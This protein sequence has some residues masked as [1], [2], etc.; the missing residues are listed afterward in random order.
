MIGGLTAVVLLVR[1]EGKKINAGFAKRRYSSRAG[2]R[3]S[4]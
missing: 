1:L 4:L 3:M 2:V